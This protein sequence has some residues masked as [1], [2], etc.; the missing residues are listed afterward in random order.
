LSGGRRIG[1]T[2]NPKRVGEPVHFC[3]DGFVISARQTEFQIGVPV[4][5]ENESRHTLESADWCKEF[6]HNRRPP[7]R[8]LI[9]W[10]VLRIIEL[11]EAMRG[12]RQ[13][14]RSNAALS[15]RDRRPTNSHAGATAHWPKSREAET[16]ILR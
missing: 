7:R 10:R 1:A 8:R 13:F 16:R 15:I 14:H 9:K 12:V 2:V 6:S 5:Q 4:I 11:I 3:F